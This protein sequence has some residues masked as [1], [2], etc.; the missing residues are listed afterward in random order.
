MSRSDLTAFDV[1]PTAPSPA[2]RRSW[3]TIAASAVGSDHER[4]GIGKQDA[5]ARHPV[6][7]DWIIAVADGAG[8]A[9]HSAEGA[10]LA[11]QASTQALEQLLTAH[12][13]LTL[14]L[15]TAIGDAMLE[16]ADRLQ[17]LATER[18]LP[19]SAFH[20]TLAV[21]VIN[22]WRV[23]SGQIGDGFLV[24]ELDD[25]SL[26]SLATPQKGEY[27]NETQFLTTISDRDEIETTTVE[28]IRGLAVMTDGLLRLAAELPDYTPHP[29]F[30]G[31]LFAFAH[32]TPSE[33]QGCEELTNLLASPRVRARTSDDLT[34]VIAVRNEPADQQS[35]EPT[36][37]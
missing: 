23:V 26:R 25:G 21:C 15:E 12:S 29:R 18:S 7:N 8:S 34:L 9:P 35:S 13:A 5:V 14:D 31:P 1:E 33:A 6:G 4:M 2:H 27:A 19:V 24:A 17:A 36:P 32:S 28:G 3:F 37:I 30:F 10:A 22:D 16:A 20:T 11:V